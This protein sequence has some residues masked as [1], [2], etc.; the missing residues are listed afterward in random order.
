MI[1]T[2]QAK[3][4]EVTFRAKKSA[5]VEINRERALKIVNA[6][7]A[8]KAEEGVNKESQQSENASEASIQV[9]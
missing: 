4:F 3:I 1:R 6:S 7:P 2:A 5:I 9:N 8:V